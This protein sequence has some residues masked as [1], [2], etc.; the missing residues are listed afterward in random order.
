[1]NQDNVQKWY[2]YCI[3]KGYIHM[4]D[5]Y[6]YSHAEEAAEDYGLETDDIKALFIAQEKASGMTA[7]E[8]YQKERSQKKIEKQKKEKREKVQKRKEKLQAYKPWIGLLA[9]FAFAI[10][11][12]FNALKEFSP[13]NPYDE[14]GLVIFFVGG[15]SL[16]FISIELKGRIAI[17]KKAE[18]QRAE[19]NVLSH[20]SPGFFTAL[21]WAKSCVS[22]LRNDN[23]YTMSS[24]PS[25]VVAVLVGPGVDKRGEQTLDTEKCACAILKDNY[26]LCTVANGENANLIVSYPR[27]TVSKYNILLNQYH[28]PKLNAVAV[29]VGGVTTGGVYKTGDYYSQH[30]KKTDAYFLDCHIDTLGFGV[31]DIYLGDKLLQKAKNNITIRHLLEPNTNHLKLLKQM[32][33]QYSRNIG[34]GNIGLHE[35]SN[36]LALDTPS[37]MLTQKEA[38]AIKDLLDSE[39]FR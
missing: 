11:M 10:L 24:I 7:E 28:P 38:Q 39:D 27:V 31:F 20:S 36:L 32:N 2:D 13:N 6:D 33:Q 5:P 25:S 19:F 15:I 18:K 1:M 16:A 23:D 21:T 8:K 29:S 22:S 9:F 34:V 14:Y 35:A 26:Q 12:G 37:M 30:A 4:D 3:I 17:E